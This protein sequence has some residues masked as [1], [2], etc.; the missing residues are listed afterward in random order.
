MAEDFYD[1]RSGFETTIAFTSQQ[2]GPVEVG[3]LLSVTPPK[4]SIEALKYTPLD[5]AN[6][7]QERV[8]TGK[9]AAGD[10]TFKIAY[11]ATRKVAIEALLGI[12]GTWTIRYPDA[13]TDS[14]QGFMAEV[15]DEELN[16]TA[17]ASTTI[18]VQNIDGWTFAAA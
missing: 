15:G 4:K 2:T 10:W 5:P 16:D 9:K 17:L 8:V 1:A 12:V 18:K 14:G 7:R 13:A 3:V 6:E 11:S